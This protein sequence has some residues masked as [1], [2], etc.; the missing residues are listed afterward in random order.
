MEGSDVG[1]CSGEA[2]AK[3]EDIYMGVGGLQPSAMCLCVRLN[4]N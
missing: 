1:E 2:S 3:W 4:T